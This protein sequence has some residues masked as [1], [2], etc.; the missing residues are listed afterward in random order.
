MCT[1]KIWIR[2]LP[3]FFEPSCERSQ[4]CR[5]DRRATVTR[6]SATSRAV[7]LWLIASNC[8]VMVGWVR[9]LVYVLWTTTAAK[10]DR[11]SLHHS[12]EDDL[13]RA[14][15]TALLLSFVE[16]LNA[17]VGVTRSKPLQVLLFAMVRFGVEQWVAPLLQSSSPHCAASWRH[18]LTVACWSLGDSIRFGCLAMDNI[19]SGG[20][21]WAK[22]V[23]YTVGPILFPVGFAGEM[24]M[25]LAAARA[26]PTPMA[27]WAMYGAASLWPVGFYPLY[28]QLLRQRRKFVSSQLA[29]KKHADAKDE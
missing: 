12:C 10:D 17:L 15:H 3:I 18:L 29:T 22:S 14:L 25:V 20:S 9:V 28:A 27:R 6:M 4:S 21:V 11:S 5:L 16:V 24:L 8:A 19:V 26:R 1:A 2:Q 13:T 23:R 7:R